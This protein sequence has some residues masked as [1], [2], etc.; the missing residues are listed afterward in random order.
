M[1]VGGSWEGA[2][3]SPWRAEYRSSILMEIQGMLQCREQLYTL[4]TCE[5]ECEKSYESGS[6]PFRTKQIEVRIFPRTSQLAISWIAKSQLRCWLTF[7]RHFIFLTQHESLSTVSLLL[8]EVLLHRRWYHSQ[9]SWPQWKNNIHTRRTTD[10]WWLYNCISTMYFGLWK[11]PGVSERMWNVYL[12]ASIS[13]E[14]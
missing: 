9:Q 3:Q 13:G 2:K 11:P 8:E 5:R 12:E 7:L 14:Y 1:G 6:T 10:R 4:Q